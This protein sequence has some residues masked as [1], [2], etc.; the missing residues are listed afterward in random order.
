M[1]LFIEAR[2]V[3]N[4]IK[5]HGT[6]HLGSKQHGPWS[7]YNGPRDANPRWGDSGYR[8]A[9]G[10]STP[11]EVGPHGEAHLKDNMSR[12]EIDSWNAAHGGP[13]PG[14]SRL[15][16]GAG[17][18]DI[19]GKT[20]D[21]QDFMNDERRKHISHFWKQALGHRADTRGYVFP[22]NWP[23]KPDPSRS[24]NALNAAC[25]RAARWP[26]APLQESHQH[27]L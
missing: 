14:H 23:H 3:A 9:P 13:G 15:S 21:F 19:K 7:G 18:A 4:Y 10:A 24:V 11:A 26:R 25:A 8:P 16:V 27:P 22:K 6:A 2:W 5:K 12:T 20:S 17:L 1:Y